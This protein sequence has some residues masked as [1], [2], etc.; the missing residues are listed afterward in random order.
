M[1]QTFQSQTAFRTP[2][3]AETSFELWPLVQG[4]DPGPEQEA[5]KKKDTDKVQSC[6]QPEPIDS[7]HSVW[8]LLRPEGNADPALNT[9][10]KRP[11]D[12]QGVD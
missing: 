12:M 6:G 4:P 5:S 11:V 10:N 7:R 2:R 8:E 1:V 3:Q 9:L